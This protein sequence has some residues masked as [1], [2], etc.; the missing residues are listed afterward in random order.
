MLI[1]LRV[2]EGTAGQSQQGAAA[3]E[4]TVVLLRA[5]GATVGIRWGARSCCPSGRRP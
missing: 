1:V 4:A 3:N 2:S 5:N